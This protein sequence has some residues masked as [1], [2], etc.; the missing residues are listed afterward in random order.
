MGINYGYIRVSSRDQNVARQ[1]YAMEQKGIERK[2][3]YIDKQSGKNFERKRYQNLISKMKEEDNLFVGSIN[4]FGRN[5][6]E[7]TE[8]WRFLIREKKINIIVMDMP[9]LDTRLQK[10]L[11]GN[12]IA[13]LVL[14]I[15]SYVAES[16]RNNIRQYQAEGIARAKERGVKFGRPPLMDMGEFVEQYLAFQAAGYNIKEIAKIMNM[17]LSTIYRYKNNIG[18]IEDIQKMS[19]ML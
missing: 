11:L 16:E 18:M 14:Y 8:Q 6:I 13:D 2:N 1:I 4:R 5:Y 19:D 3:I 17:S 10:D 15:L 7:I 12:F 9:L